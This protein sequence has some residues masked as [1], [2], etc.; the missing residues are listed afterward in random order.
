MTKQTKTTTTNATDSNP[1]AE[2]QQPYSIGDQMTHTD[3]RQLIE[4]LALMNQRLGLLV[5][6]TDRQ[7]RTINSF[8]TQ[9][10][11]DAV[12]GLVE[13]RVDGQ[14]T[15]SIKVRDTRTAAKAVVEKVTAAT[16]DKQD[17]WSTF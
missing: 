9:K 5:I 17:E 1:P 16:A 2:V 4:S 14:G 11:A 8:L 10:A 3:A 15:Q 13:I 12:D 7:S 6:A